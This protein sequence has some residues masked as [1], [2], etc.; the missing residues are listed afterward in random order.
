MRL[1]PC[2]LV[3]YPFHTCS[4]SSINQEAEDVFKVATVFDIEA[5]GEEEIAGSFFIDD[6]SLS[7]V[8]DD[9]DGVPPSG[10]SDLK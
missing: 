7:A 2:V 3:C 9:H 6:E 10:V 4:N 1:A 8:E 5:T